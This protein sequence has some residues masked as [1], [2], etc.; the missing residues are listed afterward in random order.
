[1][2]P[3][4]PWRARLRLALAALRGHVWLEDLEM[5]GWGQRITLR[6]REHVALLKDTDR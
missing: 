2:I 6:T 1:M 5:T 3:R 4:L